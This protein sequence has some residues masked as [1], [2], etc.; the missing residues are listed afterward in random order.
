MRDT[1]EMLLRKPELCAFDHLGVKLPSA[2]PSF[3]GSWGEE[4][5]SRTMRFA[6]S[7]RRP[8]ESRTRLPG[9]R[10]PEACGHREAFGAGAPSLRRAIQRLP[11]SHLADSSSSRFSYCRSSILVFL[12]CL[13]SFCASEPLTAATSHSFPWLF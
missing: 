3:G 8:E 5:Y 1:R 6:A 2:H 9:R 13:S 10:R 11:A 12:E 4:K 7:H